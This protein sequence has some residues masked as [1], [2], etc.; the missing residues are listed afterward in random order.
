MQSSAYEMRLSDW[1][2]DV[3]SSDLLR[4][5][6]EFDEEEL[7]V[8]AAVFRQIEAGQFLAVGVVENARIGVRDRTEVLAAFDAF[9]DRHSNDD[10]FDEIGRASCRERVCQYV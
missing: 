3:C 9:V 8:R 1:S 6:I 2:S 10:L 5:A 7:C 4:T